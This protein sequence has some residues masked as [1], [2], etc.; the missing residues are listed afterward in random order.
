MQSPR[1]TQTHQIKAI[2]HTNNYYRLSAIAAKCLS[3]QRFTQYTLSLLPH[4]HRVKSFVYSSL[5]LK[6]WKTMHNDVFLLCSIRQ[7]YCSFLIAKICIKPHLPIPQRKLFTDSHWWNK[8]FTV[9]TIPAHINLLIYV[10]AFAGTHCTYSWWH[11]QA[12]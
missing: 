7:K 11:G 2:K 12:E 4:R 3:T 1:H 9:D 8:Y 5:K 10:P 6:H